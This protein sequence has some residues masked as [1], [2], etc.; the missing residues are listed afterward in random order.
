MLDK[1]RQYD[2]AR[3]V[4]VDTPHTVTVRS[5]E[6]AAAAADA[7]GFPCA[8]KPV[9]SHLFARH[10][11]ARAKLWV[12]H[13]HAELARTLADMVELG[14]EMLVTEI[15]PGPDDA[16]TS[17]Y[18]YLDENGESLLHFTKRKLRQRPPRFGLGTYHVSEWSEE[19]AE[20][21]LRF[22]KG[23]GLRGIAAV[24]FKRDPRDGKL[25]LM[26]CNHR[27][28]LATEL[29]RIAGIDVARLIYNRLL[30]REVPRA[31]GFRDGVRLWLPLDDLR[32]LRAYRRS[33]EWTTG[34][35]L[36]SVAYR[37]HFPVLRLDDPQPALLEY[38]RIG[39]RALRRR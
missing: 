36:R 14:L 21:G 16:H 28:T 19:T 39:R 26:E 7:I 1:G 31:D 5:A 8:L 12:V 27:L 15:I 23:V 17:Y 6:D 29:L 33:G 2:L 3:Q 11:S 13:D 25:K 37:Q 34:R 32:A 4:G 20:A 35:W 9:H 18:G 30:G 10:F 24:E 38:A 22:L